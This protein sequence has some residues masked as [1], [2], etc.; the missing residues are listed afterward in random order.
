MVV[1]GIHPYGKTR[2]LKEFFLST[3]WLE[4]LT[5][6]AETGELLKSLNFLK[7]GK[8]ISVRD[9]RA[10]LRVPAFAPQGKGRLALEPILR[11]N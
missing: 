3:K 2:I 1:K 10:L 4:T 5:L 6:A 11:T 9:P 8:D 7:R